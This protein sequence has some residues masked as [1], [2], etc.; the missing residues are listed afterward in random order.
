MSGSMHSYHRQHQY[1]V[2]GSASYSANRERSFS[3]DSVS[4]SSLS[5]YYTGNR[6]RA[7]TVEGDSS[8]VS[9]NDYPRG[10]NQHVSSGYSN[11]GGSIH[12]D[13]SSQYSFD[14]LV[15]KSG[16]G[17]RRRSHRPRGCRGGRKNRKKSQQQANEQKGAGTEP[18]RY[19]KSAKNSKDTDPSE[20][21]TS[22]MAFA[23]TANNFLGPCGDFLHVADHVGHCGSVD[24][25]PHTGFSGR[26][27]YGYSD[28]YP[29]LQTF[30]ENVRNKYEMA[31]AANAQPIHGESAGYFYMSD[32]QGMYNSTNRTL[33]Y[34][35]R[36]S[37]PLPSTYPVPEHENLPFN[38]ATSVKGFPS[39][40]IL[41]PPPPTISESDQPAVLHGENPYALTKPPFS[42]PASVQKA[43]TYPRSSTW[44]PANQPRIA[45]TKS[46]VAAPLIDLCGNRPGIR[47]EHASSSLFAISPRSF[48]TGG[49]SNGT[50]DGDKLVEHSKAKQPVW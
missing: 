34:A 13:A 36:N 7:N 28:Q 6:S 29:A 40:E 19:D 49:S 27:T 2:N 15:A 44:C 30:N 38:N 16:I 42:Q 5:G 20:L 41:P 50:H 46:S 33:K 37:N 9:S 45:V 24:A 35:S 32:H 10:T 12:N 8:S 39:Q 43:V 48:L 21:S 1:H 14:S 3:R 11:D 47:V 4:S 22:Q 31:G 26:P 25:I 17:A 18:T 23:G